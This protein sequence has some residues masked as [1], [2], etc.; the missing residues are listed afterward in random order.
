MSAAAD[1]SLVAQIQACP[2]INS[3]MS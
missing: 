1:L 3:S 2:K